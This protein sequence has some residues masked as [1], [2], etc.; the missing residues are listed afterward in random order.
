[1]SNELDELVKGVEEWSMDK[2]V[3]KGNRFREQG[4]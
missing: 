3:D 2:G 4:K 1:M